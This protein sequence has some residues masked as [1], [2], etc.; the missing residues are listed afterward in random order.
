MPMAWARPGGLL[1]G[2]L[3]AATAVAALQ[4][5]SDAI[6]PTVEPTPLKCEKASHGCVASGLLGGGPTN[7][8]PSRRCRRASGRLPRCISPR[9]TLLRHST[10]PERSAHQ[11]AA[12]ARACASTTAA[13]PDQI[14]NF[15]HHNCATA[16]T[17]WRIAR[18]P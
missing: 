8:P 12:G 16:S 18:V 2:L 4:A 10:C 5:R 14:Q 15:C 11:Q 6:A 9:G 7:L 1:C 3:I 17:G 13:M